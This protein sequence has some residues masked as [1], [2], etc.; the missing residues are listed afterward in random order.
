MDVENAIDTFNDDFYHQN[1]NNYDL[2]DIDLIK[3]SI[4]LLK[5]DES[6]NFSE[7]CMIHQIIADDQNIVGIT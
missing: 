6:A 5:L 1:L 2:E 3:R 4:G 7:L